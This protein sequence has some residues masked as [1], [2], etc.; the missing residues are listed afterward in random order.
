MDI[1]KSASN[2]RVEW[3][4]P[5]TIC[6]ILM[7]CYYCKWEAVKLW[8]PISFKQESENKF[9]T[10]R[11]NYFLLICMVYTVW[12]AEIFFQ[13]LSFNYWFREN[14]DIFNRQLNCVTYYRGFLISYH[15]AFFVCSSKY[16]LIQVKPKPL[17]VDL[18]AQS[19][20]S[21]ILQYLRHSICYIS[22]PKN[23]FFWFWLTF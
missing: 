2:T 13:M 3:S 21:P 15:K 22:I 8:S 16:L 19:D 23:Y 1:E 14:M 7:K 4:S 12:E 5:C 18:L 10:N 20:L 17:L 9:K 11:Q 6:L